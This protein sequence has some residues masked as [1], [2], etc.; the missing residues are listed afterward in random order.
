MLKFACICPHPP[1]IIPGI[2]TA[3]DLKSVHKTIEAMNI[4]AQEISKKNIDTLIVISPHGQ[5]YPDRMNVS[6]GGEFS[7]D[8]KQFNAKNIEFEYLSDDN[9]AQKIIDISNENGINTNE[10]TEN[11]ILDHGIMVPMY[12]LSQHLSENL[13]IIPINYSML[14]IN[15]H[16]KFGEI[17]G[18]IINSGEYKNKNVGIV[19][20]GDLSH[21][22]F[23]GS[24][25]ELPEAGKEFDQKIT[26]DIKNKNIE[27]ILE[28]DEYWVEAA[29][30]CGYRSIIILLG[31]L[32]NT[33]YDSKILSYEGPFGVGYMVANFEIHK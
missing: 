31:I 21:R 11:A 14:S 15:S 12:Y 17:I 25:D 28:Y 20:S 22:L 18:E 5:I 8:F 9:L 1:I 24:P 30:E 4:L 3:K 27:D 33:N 13:K 6:Y 7:G 10:Y 23:Y 19:A 16:F 29:G 26:A 32:S 2:G